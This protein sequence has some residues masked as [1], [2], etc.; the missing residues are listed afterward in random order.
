VKIALV[1]MRGIP[2]RYGG[3]ETFAEELSTRLAERGHEVTVYCRSYNAPDRPPNYR[4]V[5]LIHR[6]TVRRKYLDT[7]A[8][9]FICAIDA[10][11]R[12]FDV[13]LLCNAANSIFIPLFRLR[14]RSLAIN[15][16]GIERRRRKWSIFGR[17]WYRLGERLAARLPD[18]IV[19]DAEVI[20]DYYRQ[21]YGVES[22]VIA[23]GAPAEAVEGKEELRRWGLSEGN[24]VLYVSRLEPENNAHLVIE[25]YEGVRTEKRLVI[26]G[27]APYA[28]GYIAR[29]KHTHD[30]RVLFTGAIYGMGY[31]ELLAHAYCYVQATEVGGTHPALIEAMGAGRCVLA[32][33]TPENL[34]VVGEAGLIYA[35]GDVEALRKRLQE[36]I[37]QPELARKYG[38]A[39]QERVRR[40]YD[41]E[42]IADRYEALF[43]EMTAERRGRGR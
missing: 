16:D 17:G 26:V 34:E 27:D 1:G 15:V 38:P 7:V 4:G 14:G 18:R 20:R 32:N 41:W 33:G 2:A 37:D 29:L 8:H 19:A 22:V 42:R 11:C 43:G 3:F 30:P 36:V 28:K 24:Y 12:R 6:P 40:R 5:R 13:I 25:A 10:L 9:T 39:A 35:P 23:Y 31:R 21:R